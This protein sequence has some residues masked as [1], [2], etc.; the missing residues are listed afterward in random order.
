MGEDR[1]VAVAVWDDDQWA[2]L[3]GLIGVEDPSLTRLPARLE[4]ADEV[5]AALSRWTARREVDD[6]VR[7][8]QDMG[9]EA[10]PVQDFGDVVADPQLAA[11]GHF[12]TLV[13]P[14]M[15]EGIYERNGFRLSD[16]PAG[17]ART[18]PTLGQDN[19]HVLQEI[20]GLSPTEIDKLGADGA[21]D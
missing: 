6:V 19:D 3:A 17:Y 1:W 18:S 21:F 20:L 5:E 12:V 13:H 4:R 14:A 8:L 15:G 9:I 16:A 7:I 11:R 10:V 2:R